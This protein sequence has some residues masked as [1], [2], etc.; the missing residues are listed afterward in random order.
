MRVVQLHEQHLVIYRMTEWT[1]WV[2][3]E[4]VSHLCQ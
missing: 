4:L 3:Q 2:I 1:Q